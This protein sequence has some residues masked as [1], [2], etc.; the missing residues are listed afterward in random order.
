MQNQLA[1]TVVLR[2][3]GSKAFHPNAFNTFRRR[4]RRKETSFA[5]KLSFKKAKEHCY[6]KMQTTNSVDFAGMRPR[7]LRHFEREPVTFIISTSANVSL[8]RCVMYVWGFDQLK[9]KCN[10]INR[11]RHSYISC[12]FAVSFRTLWRVQTNTYVL[13]RLSVDG[14]NTCRQRREKV[15]L[16]GKH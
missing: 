4:R 14:R 10:R 6:K 12:R 3:R 8:K 1:A 13:T 15:S 2:V 5:R 9:Q 7:R 11:F 16:D